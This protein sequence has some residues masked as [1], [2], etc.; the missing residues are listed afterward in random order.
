MT[1]GLRRWL[2]RMPLILCL[3]LCVVTAILA[4]LCYANSASN[5]CVWTLDSH[6]V[7][8]LTKLFKTGLERLSMALGGIALV[9]FIERAIGLFIGYPRSRPDSRDL[10]IYAVAVITYSITYYLWLNTVHCWVDVI[11]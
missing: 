3:V 7:D 9:V 10:V 4:A 5:A 2:E 1:S 11:K 6:Y 8:V